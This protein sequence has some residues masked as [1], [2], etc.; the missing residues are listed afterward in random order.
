MIAATFSRSRACRADHGKGA[1]V[2]VPQNRQPP[3]PVES[4]QQGIAT[5]HKAVEMQRPGE[6]SQRYNQNGRGKRRG[7]L[8]VIAACIL[9]LS[10]EG[11]APLHQ[12]VQAGKGQSQQKPDSREPPPCRRETP[13]IPGSD[14]QDR[15]ESQEPPSFRVRVRSRASLPRNL[16]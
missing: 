3:L 11:I 2:G 12:E 4:T 13:G 9:S 14:R 7:E 6:K 10:K 5:V 15:Q 16:P 1:H 8:P